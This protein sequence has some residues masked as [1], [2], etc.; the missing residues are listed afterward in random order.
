[1]IYSTSKLLKL[2]ILDLSQKNICIHQLHTHYFVFLF[3]AFFCSNTSFSLWFSF[4]QISTIKAAEGPLRSYTLVR[5]KQ[6]TQI[7]M[8]NYHKIVIRAIK[9]YWVPWK[10]IMAVGGWRNEEAWKWKRLFEEGDLEAE[11]RNN[12]PGKG[13]NICTR[14]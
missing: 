2:N 4:F 14:P 8:C 12:S 6:K 11:F 13:T 10:R 1:M 9:S 5:R 7:N 3:S